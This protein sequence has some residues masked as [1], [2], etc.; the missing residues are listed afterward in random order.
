MHLSLPVINLLPLKPQYSAL[1]YTYVHIHIT[2]LQD[3]KIDWGFGLGK[4]LIHIVRQRMWSFP[5]VIPATSHVREVYLLPSNHIKFD[6][7]EF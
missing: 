5:I 7:H 2:C 3:G 4:A 6:E 1:A